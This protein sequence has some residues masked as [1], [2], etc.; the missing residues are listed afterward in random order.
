MVQKLG[1]GLTAGLGIVSGVGQFFQVF[2]AAE[3]LRRAFGF[4]HLDV[5]GAVDEKANQ[6]WQC[7][8]VAGSAE[9]L[10]PLVFIFI[11]VFGS[12]FG[13]GRYRAG[14]VRSGY[15]VLEIGVGSLF[16]GHIR[17]ELAGE[18]WVQHGLGIE[19]ELAEGLDG[20]QSASG[21]Q[22]I[23]YGGGYSLP[24]GLTGLQSQPLQ[25]LHRSLA[26]AAGRGVD[27]PLQS[28]RVVGVADQPQVAE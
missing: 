10:N 22:A 13:A 9:S 4:Q 20:H 16:L 1:Q 11:C 28:H 18:V 6:L 26:D 21:K 19:N 25:S 23:R 12:G 7:G 24:G 3:G 17:R 2:N 8:C 27:D 5:P 14:C 15:A